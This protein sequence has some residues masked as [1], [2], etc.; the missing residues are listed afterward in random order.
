MRECR[1]SLLSS[2]VLS[3]L[4]YD[5]TMCTTHTRAPIDVGNL[6]LENLDGVVV[7]QICGPLEMSDCDGS[8]VAIALI[9]VALQC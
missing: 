4:T 7:S 1:L 5:R 9:L 3:V 6:R 2:N 8:P